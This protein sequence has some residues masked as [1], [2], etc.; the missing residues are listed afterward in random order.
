MRSL[1]LLAVLSSASWAADLRLHR[2]AGRD[3]FASMPRPLKEKKAKKSFVERFFQ[4]I[5]GGDMTG[6][7]G[8]DLSRRKPENPLH[9]LTVRW[10]F[11]F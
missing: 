3:L 1:S 4:T 10:Q 8:P 7:S 6:F 2:P 9:T 5:D 11:H